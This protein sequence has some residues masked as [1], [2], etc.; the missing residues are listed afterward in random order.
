MS[1]SA[2]IIR[3]SKLESIPTGEIGDPLIVVVEGGKMYGFRISFSGDGQEKFRGPPGSWPGEIGEG[4]KA[5]KCGST[6]SIS[7]AFTHCWLL[8]R[9]LRP[10]RIRAVPTMH[11]EKRYDPTIAPIWAGSSAG[12]L[13]ACADRGGPFSGAGAGYQSIFNGFFL[14][15]SVRMFPILIGAQLRI[16]IRGAMIAVSVPTCMMLFNY[17]EEASA[18]C[19]NLAEARNV[20]CKDNME[21]KLWDP[22]SGRL[23][24]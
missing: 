17:C 5:G 21:M 12:S 10:I 23:L 6:I 20:V 19:S 4:S 2:S 15:I 7:R 11:T 24:W 3:V 8:N 18:T 1:R 13:E 9:S 14:G 22:D 16:S